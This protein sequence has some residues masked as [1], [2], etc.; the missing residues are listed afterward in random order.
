ME[1]STRIDD[2]FIRK[3]EA[4]ENATTEDFIRRYSSTEKELRQTIAYLIR[5]REMLR[6]VEL[7]QLE[8]EA[9]KLIGMLKDTDLKKL[10][11]ELECF[12]D[13][14]ALQKRLLENNDKPRD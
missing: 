8:T 6:D 14:L 9:K 4:F 2:D 1:D 10:L 7:Q 5:H 11:V 12:K 3:Y 13:I